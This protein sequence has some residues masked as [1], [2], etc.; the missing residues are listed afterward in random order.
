MLKLMYLLFP[1]LCL[2]H[3]ASRAKKAKEAL[4]VSGKRKRYPTEKKEA[5]G[6]LAGTECV[7][8]PWDITL[9][10]VDFVHLF[11]ETKDTGAAFSC[12]KYNCWYCMHALLGVAWSVLIY[13]KVIVQLCHLCLL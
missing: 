6:W 7:G 8:F 3:C 12:A 5:A 13:M 11:D 4:V 9:H 1:C 10:V 2:V